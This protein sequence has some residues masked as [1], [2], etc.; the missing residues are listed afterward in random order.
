[1]FVRSVCALFL[2]LFLSGCMTTYKEPAGT[3]IAPAQ[4]EI[5]SAVGTNQSFARLKRCQKPEKEPWFFYWE[6]DLEGCVLL[7][8]AEQ[9]EWEKASS[10]GALPQVVAAT[11]VG[12]GLAMSGGTTAAAGATVNATQT[13]VQT[14][15]GG[16]H[17]R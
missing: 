17:R 12:T 1:M 4:V 9:D 8:K 5:R 16:K 10:P 13:A 15:T 14:V 11:A 7:T 2:I 6:R 3:I